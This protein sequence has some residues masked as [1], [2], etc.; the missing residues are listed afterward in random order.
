MSPSVL[1]TAELVNKTTFIKNIPLLRTFH[2]K[3]IWDCSFVYLK[4]DIRSKYVHL[5]IAHFQGNKKRG[6][7]RS[8]C[9]KQRPLQQMRV[10][11]GVQ[12]Q[13]AKQDSS[14]SSDRGYH[15][16]NPL[17]ILNQTPAEDSG[18]HRFMVADRWALV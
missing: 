4:K 17:C 2:I 11:C 12:S 16:P 6:G 15:W 3:N 8:W 14:S 5:K 1:M 10:M 13:R 7:I 18:N 9:E